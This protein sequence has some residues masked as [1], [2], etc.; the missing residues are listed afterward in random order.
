[1][2]A[3]LHVSIFAMC[4]PGSL[5]LEIQMDVV[6]DHLFHTLAVQTP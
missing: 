1:M 3:C 6:E 4:M 2:S 5:V